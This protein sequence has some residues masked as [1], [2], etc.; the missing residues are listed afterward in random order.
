MGKFGC[1]HLLK[2]HSKQSIDY[3]ISWQ[4]LVD[5]RSINGRCT[6]ALLIRAASIKLL[7]FRGGGWFLGVCVYHVDASSINKQIRGSNPAAQPFVCLSCRP[8]VS[9]VVANTISSPA[10]LPLFPRNPFLPSSPFFLPSSSFSALAPSSP[11]RHPRPTLSSCPHLTPLG[12]NC[13]RCPFGSG[14][15]GADAESRVPLPPLSTV[16]PLCPSVR[17]ILPHF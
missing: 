9:F 10:S 17:M 11:P 16:P 7:I 15:A 5:H 4:S 2:M 12:L 3:Q 14:T 1:F 8:F 13:C 6:V